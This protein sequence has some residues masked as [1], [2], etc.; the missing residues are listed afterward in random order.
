[1]SQIK[2]AQ[3]SFTLRLQDVCYQKK[4]DTHSSACGASGGPEF[5]TG[6]NQRRLKEEPLEEE[7]VKGQGRLSALT[8][9]LL[10]FEFLSFDRTL[11][12]IYSPE[13]KIS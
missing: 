12:H 2:T 9:D 6:S 8:L 1:M 10:F 3:F 11:T 4:K 7:K 5:P 13:G